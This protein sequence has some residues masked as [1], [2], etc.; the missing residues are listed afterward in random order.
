MLF[1]CYCC[2]VRDGLFTTPW[3]A[4]AGSSVLHY[5]PEFAQTHVHWVSDAIQPSHPLL[6]PSPPALN[7]SQHQGL[8]QWVSS[9]LCKIMQLRESNFHSCTC[10]PSQFLLNPKKSINRRIF[11]TPLLKQNHCWCGWWPNPDHIWDTLQ[12]ILQNKVFVFASSVS[13]KVEAQ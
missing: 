12:G 10:L 1:S 7:I 9:S 6:P 8:F 5:L 3:T 11:F 2:S 4:E 13:S